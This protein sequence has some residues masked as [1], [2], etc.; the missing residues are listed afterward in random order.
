MVLA[1]ATISV[2]HVRLIGEIHD[3][4]QQIEFDKPELAEYEEAHAR[5]KTFKARVAYLEERI[6]VIRHEKAR[7]T[8]AFALTA[9]VLAL[10]ELRLESLT[11]DE[12]DSRGDDD[13]EEQDDD[14]IVTFVL[15][16]KRPFQLLPV[17]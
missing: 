6:Q 9:E 17:T 10:P 4:E 11:M 15:L 12:R 5:I 8:G 3:L 16:R 7:P 1:A 14:I 2:L 13:A